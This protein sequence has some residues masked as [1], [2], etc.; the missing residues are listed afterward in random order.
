MA[1]VGPTGVGKTTCARIVSETLADPWFGA[2]RISGASLDLNAVERY[3]GNESPFRY[4]TAPNYF[5]VLLIEELECLPDKARMGMKDAWDVC[6]ERDWRAVVIATS[7]DMSRLEPAL[8]DRFGDP[9]VFDGGPQFAK[10]FCTWMRTTVW[11]LES[12]DP[13]PAEYPL[14]GFDDNGG[15]SG[16]RA[17]DRLEA[18]LLRRKAGVPA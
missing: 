5:G 16:R 10:A 1:F 13:I 4:R 17:L 12:D 7:N 2:H 6:R 15:F 8:R 9:F 11:R 18:E 14:W 3:F